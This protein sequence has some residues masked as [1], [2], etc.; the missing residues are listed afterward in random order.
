MTPCKNL[1]GSKL[2]MIVKTQFSGSTEPYI[3]D[4]IVY[5]KNYAWDKQ[6][7]W[8]ICDFSYTRSEIITNQESIDIGKL[9]E[10]LYALTK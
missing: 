7:W 4:K 6:S 2:T 3:E 10:F 8:D 1:T 5:L 9:F